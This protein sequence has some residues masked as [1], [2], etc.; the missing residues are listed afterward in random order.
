MTV[1]PAPESRAWKAFEPYAQLVQ[2]LMPLATSVHVF[3]D[4]GWLRWSN[5]AM[6][7]P[8]LPTAVQQAQEAA[9]RDPRAVGRLLRLEGD[10]SPVYLWWLRD[11]EGTFLATIAVTTHRQGGG[12]TGTFEGVHA[13]VRPAIECLRTQLV[14]QSSLLRLHR[15]LSARDKDVELL[16][17]VADS[18]PAADGD[19]AEDLRTL[20][21]NAT[22]HMD[23][24][25]G[26]LIVP[27]KSIAIMATPEGR[28]ADSSVL[29]RTHRQLLQLV[30]T[31]R[32][33]VVINRVG[34]AAEQ[35]PYRILCCPVRHPGGRVT[36]VLALFR[37]EDGAEFQPRDARLIELVARRATARIEASYDSLTGLLTRHAF[38]QAASQRMAEPG[39][40][41]EWCA[42][43]VDCDQLHVINDN[44]GMHTGDGVLTQIGELVRGRM[45]P[46]ALGARISG[47]RFGI[48]VPLGVFQAS[49]C[50]EQ[51]RR[52]AEQIGATH[53]SAR[54]HTSITIGVAAIEGPGGDGL[55][56]AFAAAESACKAGKDR[57]RNRV[58]VHEDTDVSLI[59]R[60]TD[61]TT[62][63]DLRDAIADGR[64]RLDAQLIQPLGPPVAGAVPHYELLL[65]MIGAQG[66]TLGPE[67]F[68]SAAQRYQMMPTID[69]WVFEQ[70]VAKLKPHAALL[71]AGGV[72][73]SINFSGQSLNDPSFSEF[74]LAGIE[75]CGIA[76]RAFCFE[77]T[78]SEAVA[79]IARAELLMRA[80]RRLGCGV[81]LDDFGTG[82]SSLAYLKSL[83]VT[84][85]KIDGSFVRDILRDPRSESM[86]Q[87]ITQLAHTM[88]IQTVAEYVETE[89]IRQRI[90]SI[91]VDFGQGFAI[92]RPVP[93]DGILEQLPLLVAAMPTAKA[94]DAAEHVFP[95]FE[96]A[97]A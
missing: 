4:E 95:L 35:L 47:D 65:R 38:D 73:F 93:L 2:S 66:E 58:E 90:G 23:C 46:G 1:D 17:S 19:R 22:R 81:A 20:L 49:E 31:R 96:A 14:M 41:K 69:R 59:R 62:S 44:F 85:L 56:H 33:A 50:A 71:A 43:Y 25:L 74:L 11:D 86:V 34:T 48:A 91:G 5:E 6:T 77:L 83:P 88:S 61:I 21:H 67:R 7:G 45:P 70:A 79:S 27:E 60:F 40:P 24:L 54:L 87:A 30:Q 97:R 3:D 64:L 28:A 37:R 84:L 15:S 18:E 9:L 82:L 36:G 13:V 42:L 52:A 94:A 26:A 63:T 53:T 72:V 55:A 57:G 29:A 76:P 75:G 12:D 51:L 89:E 68:M 80:L 10:P 16:L 39:R 92:A 78:E 32:E 8:D